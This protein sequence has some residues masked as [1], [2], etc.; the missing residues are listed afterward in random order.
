MFITYLKSMLNHNIKNLM[1]YFKMYADENFTLSDSSQLLVLF[2]QL[3]A[4]FW[5]M[6]FNFQFSLTL[7]ETETLQTLSVIAREVVHSKSLIF[8]ICYERHIYEKT[9]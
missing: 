9:V 6:L 5:H 8:T 1:R 7:Q 3:V 4:I 2:W